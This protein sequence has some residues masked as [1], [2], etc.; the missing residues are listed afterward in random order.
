MTNGRHQPYTDYSGL[1]DD[2][3]DEFVERNAEKMAK[4]KAKKV[5]AGASSP[6]GRYVYCSACGSRQK[7][8]GTCKRCGDTN[9]GESAKTVPNDSDSKDTPA[10]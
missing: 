7:I 2:G 6:I 9:A 5:K 1:Y 4:S 10:K 3:Y 8:N